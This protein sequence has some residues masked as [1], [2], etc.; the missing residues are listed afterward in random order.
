ML[1][2]IITVGD[3]KYTTQEFMQKVLEQGLGKVVNTSAPDSPLKNQIMH[4]LDLSSKEDSLV[5]LWTNL[6]RQKQGKDPLEVTTQDDVNEAL[7]PGGQL[8]DYDTQRTIRYNTYSG[9]ALTG[10]SAKLS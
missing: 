6:E 4:K 2:C 10:I 9:I 1:N 7:N 5:E 3:N 8:S